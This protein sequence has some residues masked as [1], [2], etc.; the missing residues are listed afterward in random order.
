MKV[1]LSYAPADKEWAKALASQLSNAGFKTWYADEELFPGDNWQLRIG[2]ALE[3]SDAM[4]VLLSPDW[5]ESRSARQEI[6]YA[7]GSPKFGGRLISVLIRPTEN[8]PW[9]LRRLQSVEGDPREV[10]KRIVE[11]LKRPPNLAWSDRAATR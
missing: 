8:I 5:A 9:I 11:I 6:Q 4:I 2:Q 3:D 1:F 10:G 7:L